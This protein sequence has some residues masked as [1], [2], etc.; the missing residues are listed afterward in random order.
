MIV[1]VRLSSSEF[2]NDNLSLGVVVLLPEVFK[3][4]ANIAITS[5]YLGVGYRCMFAR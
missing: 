4:V 1:H 3:S 2:K 5:I